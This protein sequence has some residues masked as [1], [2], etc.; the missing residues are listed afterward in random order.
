MALQ[1]YLLIDGIVHLQVINHLIVQRARNE[2]V[3][4]ALEAELREHREMQHILTSLHTQLETHYDAWK[5]RMV[6]YS[7]CVTLIHSLAKFQ[8]PPLS[9]LFYCLCV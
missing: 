4:M 6:H 2:F 9:V 1:M 8:L 5:A 7:G 3:S